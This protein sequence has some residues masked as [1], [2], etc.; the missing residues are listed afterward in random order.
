MTPDSRWSQLRTHVLPRLWQHAGDVTLI[1]LSGEI[2]TAATSALESFLRTRVDETVTEL[3]I[4]LG[5]VTALSDAGTA[6]LIRTGEEFMAGGRR[7]RLV[8]GAPELR[9]ALRD[10][11]PES[12]PAIFTTIEAAVAARECPGEAEATAEAEARSAGHE[13]ADDELHRLREQVRQLRAD[14]RT[15]PVVARAL[16]VLQER[17]GLPDSNT[18]F[19]LLRKSSQHHNLKLRSVA[20]AF[21]AAPPPGAASEWWFPGRVRSPAPAVTFSARIQHGHHNRTSFL[22]AVLD[23]ALTCAGTEH[24]DVQ[25]VDPLQ[26]G[27]QLE[28]QRG[29]SAEF[30]D[31]FGYA[32]D[33]NSVPAIALRRRTRVVVTDVATDP[34]FTGSP[35]RDVLLAAG[36]R[37]TQSTPLVA[38]SG[39]PVGVVSTHDP[40]PGPAT[41]PDEQAP[42][43]R[44]GIEGGAWLEW[45]QETIMLD[46]LE[47]LHRHA[48][49]TLS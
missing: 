3:V 24:G 23:A 48:R 29:F 8:V 40:R 6:M 17:Y 2:D 18:A 41:G 21:L 42:L 49:Q 11:H 44:I 37:S 25:L 36:I 22:E 9:R 34:V 5:E 27:L 31:F 39:R 12:L 28:T 46:T 38:A 10:A 26:G 47:H 30:M 35:A 7:L 20:A 45:H 32:G 13:N 15:R 16:G 43:D 33:E 1:C 4:D 19:T 14:L